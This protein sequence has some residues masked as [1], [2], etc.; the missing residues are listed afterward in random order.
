MSKAGRGER[1]MGTLSVPKVGA[2]LHSPR[3]GQHMQDNVFSD[4][5][6]PQVCKLAT[7]GPTRGTTRLVH[8]LFCL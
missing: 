4:N 5:L 1:A 2:M 8:T 3:N 6:P 7:I